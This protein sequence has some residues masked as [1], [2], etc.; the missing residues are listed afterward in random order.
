VTAIVDE[1]LVKP[2]ELSGMGETFPNQLDVG[3][4]PIKCNLVLVEGLSSGEEANCLR[5]C[6][7]GD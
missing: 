2:F 5:Y 6:L 3:V 1:L 7:L 4:L